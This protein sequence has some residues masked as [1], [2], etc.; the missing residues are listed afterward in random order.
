MTERTTG[1]MRFQ[2]HGRRRVEGDFD[3]GLISSHGGGLL[4]R[5]V[6][7]RH[8]VIDQFA[9]CFTDHRDPELVEHSV[10]DL[11]AQRVLAIALGYEDLND[12]DE[13][14]KDPLL[15]MLV[16]KLDVTGQDRRVPA[17][18]GC[19]LA[20]KST[21]NRLELSADGLDE[22]YRKIAA[23]TERIALYFV[24]LYI[25]LHERPERV[26][27][28]FDATDDPLHGRQEGRFF[29]G[30]YNEYCYL[31]LYAFAGDF[32]LAAVL[33]EASE[34]AAAGAVEQLRL[35]VGQL[36]EAWPGVPVLLRGDS[37][38]CRDEIMSWCEDNGVDYLLGVSRNPR[39]V[40]MIQPMLDEVA[41][42]SAA[43]GEPVRQ[44]AELR[45]RTLDSWRQERRVVAKAEALVD[46]QNPRFIVTCLPVDEHPGQALYEEDYCGRGEMENRIKE[47]QLWLFAD[48]TST[49]SFAANQMRLT[50]S[51]LAYV[52]IAILRDTYLAG[53]E[54]ARATCQTIRL[55]LLRLGVRL[56]ISVRRLY[57]SFSSAVPD[58]GLFRQTL[59]RI[60]D[61]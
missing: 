22:R 14:R 15:A 49:Y 26:L 33:R 36:R 10:R 13:L 17:D 51:T 58:A 21:L 42:A 41:A 34:D 4:L 11:A 46:K 19:P 12:H 50:F 31:P 30:Y 32:P 54:L 2:A 28:D 8:Q 25:Q 1:K 24:Q 52:L 29:H 55:R 7:E 60:R 53:T 47:Q 38:F 40:G 23:D 61:G 35:I 16:G 43:S 44:F 18:R 20:G 3:G 39:L 27:L 57:L 59:A 37:G 45:Y 9:R 48:R 56:R 5:E 6:E